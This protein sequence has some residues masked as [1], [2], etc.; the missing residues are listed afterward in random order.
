MLTIIVESE[1][2]LISEDKTSITPPNFDC[3]NIFGIV[4][5]ILYIK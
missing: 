3:S 2:F 4:F 5:V 1:Q